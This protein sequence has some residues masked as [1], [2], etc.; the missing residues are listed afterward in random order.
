MA[1]H[2]R[3]DE[4]PESA[5]TLPKTESFA[6]AVGNH[7]QLLEQ[8]EQSELKRCTASQEVSQASLF[9]VHDSTLC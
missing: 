6:I 3:P 5:L 7:R 9:L 2:V 8:S 4:L 1:D